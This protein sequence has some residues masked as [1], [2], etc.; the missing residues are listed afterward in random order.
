MCPK[1]RTAFRKGKTFAD[2]RLKRCRAF[3]WRK[4]TPHEGLL[5]ATEH[6]IMLGTIDSQLHMAKASDKGA[7]LER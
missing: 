1:K 6:H 3:I 4:R 5:K 7:R 2:A